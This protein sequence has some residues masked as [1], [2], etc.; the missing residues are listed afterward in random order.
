[1]GTQRGCQSG[2]LTCLYWGVQKPGPTIATEAQTSIQAVCLADTSVVLVLTQGDVLPGP[3][4]PLPAPPTDISRQCSHGQKH[5][6][7][8]F[9][10]GKDAC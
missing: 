8:H 1:M 7:G 2:I 10:A 5:Q 4:L 3:R 6:H 9:W